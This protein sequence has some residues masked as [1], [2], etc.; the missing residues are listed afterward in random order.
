VEARFSELLQDEELEEVR[1]KERAG[2]SAL[3][4]CTSFEK[5]LLTS[6]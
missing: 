2:T 1:Q 3:A 5:A 6:S 4:L